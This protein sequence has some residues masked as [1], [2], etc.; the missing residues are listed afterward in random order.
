MTLI[1]DKISHNNRYESARVGFIEQAHTQNAQLIKISVPKKN[2][3]CKIGSS[4][5]TLD[6]VFV[7]LSP[8][9]N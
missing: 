2:I 1:F 9:F 4:T 6:K 5:T 7:L 3:Y 8:K